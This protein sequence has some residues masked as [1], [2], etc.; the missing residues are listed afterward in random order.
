MA[1][2]VFITRIESVKSDQALGL[3]DCI[4]IAKRK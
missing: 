3:T 4:F 2:T 1:T